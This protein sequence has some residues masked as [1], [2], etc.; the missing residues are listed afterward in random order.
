MKLMGA[1]VDGIIVKHDTTV[2]SYPGMSVCMSL[3][4][5]V[6]VCVC[7]CVCACACVRVCARVCA[8]MCVHFRG[9]ANMPA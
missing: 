5:Y 2:F 6:C 9:E 4:V 3:C 1:R 8:R 7:V